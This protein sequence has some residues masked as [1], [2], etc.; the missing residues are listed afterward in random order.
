MLR[1]KEIGNVYWANSN[2]IDKSDKK[3]RRQYSVVKDNGK[4]VGIAKIR[5]FNN[6][7]KNNERLFELDIKKYPL[8]KRSGIDNKVYS[9]RSDNNKLLR[10]E[11]KQVFD[12]KPSFKLS[13]HDT[14]KAIIHTISNRRHKKGRS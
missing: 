3:T 5:G 6:N 1:K 9:K 12:K 7:K 10:I 8:T 2:L 11:D 14:H 4:Y 13:S